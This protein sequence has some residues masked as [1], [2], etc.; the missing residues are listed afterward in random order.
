MRKWLLEFYVEILRCKRRGFAWH[1]LG[2]RDNAKG[3]GLKPVLPDPRKAPAS[4]GGRY[5][6]RRA[7]SGSAGG[8]AEVAATEQVQVEME[9]GLAG[10]RAV[11]EDGAIAG[12][13]VAF[14]GE[15]GGDKLELAEESGV[16]LVR[17]LQR[18]EMFP[19]TN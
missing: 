17:V 6:A 12:E 16:V 5:T 3:T 14:G 9:D 13:Q 10:A 15:L 18:G 4:E 1:G 8:P 11:V 19:G 2:P 7:A